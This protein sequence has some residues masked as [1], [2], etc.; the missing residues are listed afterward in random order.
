MRE[1]E[2]AI[3]QIT[4]KQNICQL[5]SDLH[6]T[7]ARLISGNDSQ[8]FCFCKDWNQ[9]WWAARR[10]LWLGPRGSIA[11]NPRRSFSLKPMTPRRLSWLRYGWTPYAPEGASMDLLLRSHE[12]TNTYLHMYNY[13]NRSVRLA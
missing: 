1:V 8:F 2:A 4:I 3:V 13:N 10:P 11:S 6:I 12:R 7:N 9:E 5:F